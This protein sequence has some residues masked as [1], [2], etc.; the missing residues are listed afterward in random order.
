VSGRSD[1]DGQIGGSDGSDAHAMRRLLDLEEIRDLARRYAH[2]VWQ[3]DASGAAALF[4]E[5]GEMD[6]GDRPPIVGRAAILASYDEIFESQEFRPM[7]HNH[8][9]DLD[10][11]NATGTCYLD[12]HATLDGVDKV[13]LG[14]YQDHYV[15]T[16][17]GW[18]FRSRRLTLQAFVDS[19]VSL[20]R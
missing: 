2:C 4:A 16:A 7:V 15:R 14:Y 3:R 1:G 20:S 13:G 18:K 5:D 9:I 17:E 10:G 12:L 19:A 8:V 11:E 6:T